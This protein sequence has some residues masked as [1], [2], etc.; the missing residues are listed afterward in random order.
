MTSS[1][2]PAQAADVVQALGRMA[3]AGEA[4]RAYAW[5]RR[6]R[7]E[8]IRVGPDSSACSACDSPPLP[9]K[10]WCEAHRPRLDRLPAPMRRSAMW[11]ARHAVRHGAG[12][13]VSELASE[14]R[15]SEA[16]IYRCR[17]AL[18]LGGRRSA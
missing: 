8:G 15:V 17:Q 9:G 1:L 12:R 14:A 10:R 7:Q 5:I 11:R 3:A 6:I 4:S 18:G 2:T 13:S 16:T